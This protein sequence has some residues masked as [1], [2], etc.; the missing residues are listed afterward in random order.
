MAYTTIDSPGLF[1]N[2]LYLDRFDGADQSITGVGFQPD[3]F[4][5]NVEV[6]WTRSLQ[7]GLW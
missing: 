4:G 1:F 5:L 6:H 7:F 2:T 3:W